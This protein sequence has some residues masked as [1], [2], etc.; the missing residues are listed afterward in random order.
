MIKRIDTV[1]RM[2]KVIHKKYPELDINWKKVGTS[3]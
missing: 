3:K 2:L 1:K